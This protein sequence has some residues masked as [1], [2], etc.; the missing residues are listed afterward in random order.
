M[1]SDPFEASAAGL[2]TIIGCLNTGHYW[3]MEYRFHPT[4]R[5]RFDAACPALKI[6]CEYNGG[7]FLTRK[8]GHQTAA[9]SMRDW[10]KINEAQL[11][12]WMVLQFGPIETK[13]GAALLVIERAIHIR[14]AQL[15]VQPIS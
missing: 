8:G 15:D 9:G 2:I 6:A 11:R 10:E 1:S 13:T 14:S 5:W 12:G 3:E 7:L 4:R